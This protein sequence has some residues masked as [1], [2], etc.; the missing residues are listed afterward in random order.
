MT[1][2]AEVTP[3]AVRVMVPVAVMLI[4]SP[5]IAAVIAARKLPAP[6]SAVLVTVSVAAD[7]LRVRPSSANASNRS[8]VRED[9][10]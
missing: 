8:V 1:V 5:A 4:V 10:E 3:E 6:P 7:V 2:S 9:T